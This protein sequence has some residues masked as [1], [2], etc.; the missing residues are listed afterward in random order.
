MRETDTLV[1]V[2]KEQ[3]LTLG[4]VAGFMVVFPLFWCLVIWIISFVGGWRTLAGSFAA[5]SEPVGD[6]YSWRAL[7]IAPAANYNG[8]INVVLSSG[9]IYMVPSMLFRFAHEPLLL[10]WDCLVQVSERRFL[11]RR[12]W[13]SLLA[14]GKK[15]TLMLPP[16]AEEA[17]RRYS[18]KQFP[19]R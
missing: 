5:S 17:I 11:G 7:R 18:G 1:R 8:C 3:V 6:R 15:L 13:V 10:P 4:I 2:S 14:K 19:Q 12:L 9:G 16:S